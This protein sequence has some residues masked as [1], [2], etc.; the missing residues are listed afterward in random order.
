MNTCQAHVAFSIRH[1]GYVGCA[2]RRWLLILQVD[3]VGPRGAPDRHRTGSSQSAKS[4]AGRGRRR[5][6]TCPPA[7]L[8]V[9]LYIGAVA[10]H[11]ALLPQPSALPISG[12]RRCV[13]MPTS[14][15]GS[16]KRQEP[17][18]AS[19]EVSAPPSHGWCGPKPAA[20]RACWGQSSQ[21][22]G[23]PYRKSRRWAPVLT[24]P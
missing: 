8:I 18:L 23:R 5:G 12:G 21:G 6:T 1:N 22:D 16:S 11:V 7:R 2:I 10:A 3:D 20:V 13:S 9:A 24:R 15:S 17:S 19:V 4:A 14:P